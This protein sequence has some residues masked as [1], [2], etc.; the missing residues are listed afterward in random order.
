MS[1]NWNVPPTGS[2]Y[3]NQALKVDLPNALVSLRTH[4]SGASEPTAAPAY[5][6][7]ADTTSGMLRIRNAAE[8][9]W[10]DVCPLASQVMQ[11]VPF[12]VHGAL[13]AA[14]CQAC[15]PQNCVV[16]RV[17]L[18]PD[19]STTG[20]SLGVTEWTF[21]LRNVTQALN[22]FSATVTTAAATSGIGGGELAA[23]TPYHL[24]ANQNQTAD[25]YDVLRFTVGAN[26]SPTAVADVSILLVLAPAG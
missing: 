6:T 12:H 10:V 14:E 9:A 3:A 11:V 2:T 18:V 23:D 4:F 16:Q 7:W 13:S 17:I 24:T 26:G 20:S 15:V 8:T 22:C 19:T 1:Q 21:M 5:S 25:Q